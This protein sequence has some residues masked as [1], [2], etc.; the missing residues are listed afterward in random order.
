[1]T[2]LAK[3]RKEKKIKQSEM[4]DYL[5][6]SKPT[7]CHY[8]TGRY[9]PDIKTLLKLADYFGCSVDYLLDHK[10]EADFQML[11]FSPVQQKTIELMKQM[12]T[13]QSQQL[14]N[15][16]AFLVGQALSQLAPNRPW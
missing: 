3:L 13:D 2:N 6:V 7:Y 10:T 16:A 14:F 9:E 12:D 15:Y 11:N 4:A 5:K 1:M 8:E